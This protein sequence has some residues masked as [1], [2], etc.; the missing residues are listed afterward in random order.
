MKNLNF[1]K[2]KE[3]CIPGEGFEPDPKIVALFSTRP[4]HEPVMT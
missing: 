3:L 1:L 2:R 4:L